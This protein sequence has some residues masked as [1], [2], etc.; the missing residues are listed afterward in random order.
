MKKKLNIYEAKTHFSDIVRQVCETG[1]AYTVCKNNKPVVDIVV[2]KEE[3]KK[4]LPDPLPEYNGKGG[5]LC[6]PLE[7]TED[8]WPEE[9][10]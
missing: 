2:H 8:L 9:F 5:Y 6:D 10:R 3:V 7:S 1:E 4:S